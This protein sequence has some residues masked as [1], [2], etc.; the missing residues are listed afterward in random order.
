MENPT[1]HPFY[2]MDDLPNEVYLKGS[3]AIDTEAMGLHPMRDRLCVVQI[4][5]EDGNVHIVHFSS[6]AYNCP[7]LKQLLMDNKRLKIFHFARFDVAL[8]QHALNVALQNIYCTKISSKLARTYTDQ[9]GL[10]DVCN[11][12]LNVKLSKQQQSSD[13]GAAR[14]TPE[15]VNYA[16]NDVIHLHELRHKLDAMLLRENRLEI[17]QKCFDFI[18]ARATLDLLGWSGIDIFMYP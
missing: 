5:D 9:H 3:L 17:A 8:I 1:K 7:N 11:E 6:Q 13:W 10:K 15:Q 18:P 12:L 14:L 16:A 2:H 4:C